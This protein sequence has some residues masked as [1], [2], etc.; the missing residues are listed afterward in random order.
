M[1]ILVGFG[2]DGAVDGI[3]GLKIQHSL[4]NPKP[5]FTFSQVSFCSLCP[6]F[7]MGIYMYMVP[8]NA[9]I[10]QSR[11]IPTLPQYSQDRLQIHNNPDHYKSLKKW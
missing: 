5:D 8:Y 10:S 3:A 6:S 2:M 1:Y 11:Y 9:L 7:L 4:F